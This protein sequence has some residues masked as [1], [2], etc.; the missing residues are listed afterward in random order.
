MTNVWPRNAWTYGAAARIQCTNARIVAELAGG[1]RR[2][3][4]H[5]GGGEC[6]DYSRTRAAAASIVRCADAC[7]DERDGAA[8][9]I[10]DLSISPAVPRCL[11]SPRKP[12]S[13][14]AR[15]RHAAARVRADPRRRRQR[16][17]ARAHHA[18]RVAASQTGQ[19]E[20]AG[21]PRGH[22][23]QQGGARDAD[24]PVG[25]CCRSTRAACG[26]APSTACATGMLRTHHRDAGLPQLF[27][28]LDTQDQL[29]LIKR[30]YEGARP[31]RRELS[32]R[33]SCSTS[34]TTAK[35]AGLRAERGRGGRRLHAP[36]WSSIYAVYDAQCQRE[37]VV[38][39]AE[40]L[41]RSYEL[42]VDATRAC[43]STTSAA[44][45]PPGRR[46]PGHQQAAVQVAAAA[47][48]RRRRGVRGRRRRPV[49]LRVPRR[50]RRQHAA[51]RARLR[52][53]SGPSAHQARAELPLARATSSTPPTR[54]SATTR[55]ASART[56]GRAKARASRCASSRRRTTTT[57]R[58]SSSTRC[59]ALRD[60]GVAA[61]RDRAPLPLATR[62]R[63]CSSTRS[64]ARA[65]RTASTAACASSSAQEVKHA[66]AYLRLVATP[67]DDG[68]FLRVVNFPPR[69]IGART[70]EQLQEAARRA[71]SALWQ[72]ACAGGVDRARRA[73]RSRR[74]SRLDRATARRDTRRCRCPSWSSTSSSKSGLVAHYAAEKDGQDRLENL[75]RARQRGRRFVREATSQRRADAR[76]SVSDARMRR[77]RGAARTSSAPIRSRRSSRTRRSRRATRRRPKASDALQLMT[78]HSAK[79][80]EFHA[81]FVTGLE[82]GLFP[83][84]NS[85]SRTTAS[86]RSAA[87]CTSRSRARG[88]ASTSRT[89]RAACCTAR[90]ATASCRASST[91]FRASSCSG[92]RRRA[93]AAIDVDD[94]RMGHASRERRRRT[95]RR[96]PRRASH[97]GASAR[98]CAT[99][100]SASG[101]IIDAEG[102]GTDARVQV[103][104][105]DA[106][107]KWL[108]LEYARLEAPARALGGLL[109]RRGRERLARVE[110]VAIA[111]VIGDRA[112]SRRSSTRYGTSSTTIAATR[113]TSGGDTQRHDGGDDAPAAIA[114][115]KKT[116]QPY[117]SD[118]SPVGER[119][120]QA[121]ASSAVPSAGVLEHDQRR[122]PPQREHASGARRARRTACASCTRRRERRCSAAWRR[123]RRPAP[124]DP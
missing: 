46:V 73:P 50:E 20:P 72:A 26:S 23:H 86:R 41:L 49:D 63:A 52:T 93:A 48:G 24:A 110:H 83:H 123:R 65:C 77:R 40:L 16:Q 124:V 115:K 117:T 39:F 102:R 28:I 97:R 53:P 58:A 106:G 34:S 103:N 104:F 71:A 64:S 78:V 37:G 11:A 3:R 114:P 61:R 120:A 38:D 62:S 59:K 91:R 107:V 69:G 12:Q 25:A 100:S 84:E 68:A 94:A 31:R 95:P 47:R 122:R 45:A 35:E 79:G 7:P 90:R 42:L 14:A 87:S 96:R 29:A 54:S 18:H 111:H 118:G 70:I 32:R 74:S 15:R 119:G 66:L 21:D 98:A 5:S 105:R 92:S 36:A 10:F 44:S 30:L 33:A 121:R 88:G 80:L 1:L 99:R 55:R 57:R 67:D 109:A 116:Q 22:V 108:A 81:V 101:V 76:A 9:P 112:A 113:A 85:M 75:R 82:E 4:G 19:V 2:G 27:Q 17:D 6:A 60:E 43:A 13:R 89:R 56:C 51:V 8:A